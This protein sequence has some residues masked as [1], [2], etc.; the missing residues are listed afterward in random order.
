MNGSAVK[1]V[2][3][4]GQH[5]FARLAAPLRRNHRDRR[6]GLLMRPLFELLV[7]VPASGNSGVGDSDRRDRQ[8]QDRAPGLD[9]FAFGP[10]A[11][12]GLHM[13]LARVGRVGLGRRRGILWLRLQTRARLRPDPGSCGRGLGGSVGRGLARRLRLALMNEPENRRNEQERRHGREDEAADHG[14]AERRV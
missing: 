3:I 7:I 9:G 1:S 4:A 12:S 2:D 8:E 5:E 14:A 6:D 13:I 10:I 11:F